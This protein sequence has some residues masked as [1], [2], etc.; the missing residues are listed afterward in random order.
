MSELEST[1][2]QIKTL[3]IYLAFEPDSN[4]LILIGKYIRKNFP[5]AQKST[6]IKLPLLLDIKYDRSLIAGTALVWNGIYKDFSVKSI[7]EEKK[8]IILD[9]FKKYLR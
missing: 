9:S 4:S 1:I 8:Q 2:D 6:S 3:S 7:I 5:I